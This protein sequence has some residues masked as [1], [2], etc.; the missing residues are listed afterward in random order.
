MDITPKQLRKKLRRITHL[1]RLR[2][3]KWLSKVHLLRVEFKDNIK[4]I[5]KIAE[6]D[7]AKKKIDDEFNKIYDELINL[8]ISENTI[9]DRLFYNVEYDKAISSGK[10]KK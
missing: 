3:E 1:S 2:H 8:N 10:E 9:Q 4:I 7:I 6:I 5:T